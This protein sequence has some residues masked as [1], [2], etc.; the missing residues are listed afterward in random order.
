[1]K[2]SDALS[3][4]D[5]RQLAKRR[6]PR[7]VFETIDSGVE[8]DLGPD[9]NIEAFQN[10]RL[11]P[12]YLVDV[13]KIN[14]QVELFGQPF[15]LPFGIAPTGFAGVFRRGAD[16]MM[17]RAAKSAN[18]PFILSGAS[19]ET[20]EDVARVASS[21]VWCH[22]Y[23]ARD[24]S[25][26]RDFLA[27][28]EAAGRNVLVITVDNPVYP[29]RERDTRNR[30]GKAIS[31]QKWSTIVEAATHL[32][33]TVEFLK[34]GGF[35]RMENWGR[36]APANASGAEVAA[37]FRS[38]SP[39]IITWH[40]LDDIRRK[41]PGKLII[42]GIQH[43]GDARR[44]VQAGCDGII[45]SNHGG[46]AHDPLPAPVD[47]LAGVVDAVANRIPVMLDSGI[48]RG[49][50]IVIA[51]CLGAS[52]CFVGR[53]TLYGVTAGGEA[54]VSKAIDILAR[55]VEISLALIGCP[56]FS[57]LNSEFLFGS[58]SIPI[59]S[60]RENPSFKFNTTTSPNKEPDM[61]KDN[62][63]FVDRKELTLAACRVAMDAS[64]AEAEKLGLKMTVAIV[65]PGGHALNV[66]RMDSIHA[67]TV[68]VAFAKARCAA[69]FKRPTK[70]FAEGYAGGATALPAIPGVLPF[71]G[72][73]PIIVDGHLLGAIGASGASPDQD[74]AVAAAGVEAIMTRAT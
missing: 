51:A 14:R 28:A 44:A 59:Q 43:P 5:L 27:R 68:E 1:M 73:I 53:P 62:S 67:G 60:E 50:D 2:L 20:L 35:P 54:G 16:S 72:G 70:A 37:Y 15:D 6:L 63:F 31:Q 74:A 11:F 41:W 61:A 17:A 71:A 66:A 18:I 36:Y 42:K 24:R 3:I 58:D 13:E 22:I 30:F 19:M 23:P 32:S 45:V 38:Q 47:S 33:W 10:Y 12:R 48:R 26:T 56:S 49:S 69:M 65:D 39:T 34:R 4:E 46:K 40:E 21:N 9:R 25:V 64:L 55:E 29:N 52:F 7:T 57:K 8:D